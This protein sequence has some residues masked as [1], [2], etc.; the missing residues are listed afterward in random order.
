MGGNDNII[1]ANM[2][3]VIH[4]YREST[5]SQRESHFRQTH[6]NGECHRF[7]R[8]TPNENIGS[9]SLTDLRKT[10]ID[11]LSASVRGYEGESHRG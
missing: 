3:G 2:K 1:R 8:V 4:S 9:S 11:L 7:A 5:W 10:G 6:G